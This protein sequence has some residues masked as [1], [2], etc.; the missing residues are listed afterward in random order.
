VT[1]YVQNS[2]SCQRLGTLISERLKQVLGWTIDLKTSEAYKYEQQ[3][4]LVT[5][6]DARP[7][8]CSTRGA[9]T[10]GRFVGLQMDYEGDPTLATAALK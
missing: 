9:L 5:A 7:G 2:A 10:T 6:K 4:K 3:R 1:L 8:C